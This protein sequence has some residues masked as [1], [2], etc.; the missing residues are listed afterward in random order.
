MWHLCARRQYRIIAVSAQKRFEA[1]NQIPRQLWNCYFHKITVCS[2]G[3]QFSKKKWLKEF[4][5]ELRARADEGHSKA[6]LMSSHT[7]DVGTELKVRAAEI[8]ATVKDD[9]ACT[10]MLSGSGDSGTKG[11]ST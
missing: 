11:K 9:E 2:F 4:V 3:E 7:P 5:A 1:L 6:Q 8:G 10:S